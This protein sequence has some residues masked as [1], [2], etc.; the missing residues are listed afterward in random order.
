MKRYLYLLILATLVIGPIA[1]AVNLQSI[2]Q[3]DSPSTMEFSEFSHTVMVEYGTLTT[4]GPC[5]TASAQLYSI[6][7]SGDLDFYYVS[8][9]WDE[10]NQ[11]VRQRLIE[12]GVSSVPDVFFDGGYRRLLGAQGDEQPYRDA[13]TQSGERTVPDI[14]IEVDVAWVGGGILKITGTV[15]NNEEEEFNGHLRVYIVEPL[16]RWNDNG[17]NPYHFGVLDIP[18]DGNLAVAAQSQAQPL[19]DTYTFKKTWFGFI[20]GFSDITQDNILVIASVFDKDTNYA[21]ETAAAEPTTTQGIIH[22]RPLFP[23]LRFIRNQEL[24]SH[25]L[26]LLQ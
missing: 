25:I 5:V 13:I 15:V 9:V 17:G 14:D 11:N 8:L 19:G 20:H 12:L 24:L 23:L 26:S 21:V 6:Y 10:G 18:I 1:G 7:E 3:I 16:S 2:D 4:C 22:E